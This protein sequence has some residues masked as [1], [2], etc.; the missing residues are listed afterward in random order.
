MVDGVVGS[1]APSP[2]LSEQVTQ[3]IRGWI[4]SGELK[5]G[6]RLVERE[7]CDRLEISRATLREVFRLLESDGLVTTEANRGRVVTM[8]SP[9]EAK[10]LYEAREAI[11]CTI[12]RLFVERASDDAIAELSEKLEALRALYRSGD[13][14]L[15]M[16]KK[17]EFYEVLYAGADNALLWKQARTLTHRAAR[18]RVRTLSMGNR[19]QKSFDEIASVFDAIV[20]RNPKLAEARWR[21]HIRQAA[22]SMFASMRSDENDDSSSASHSRSAHTPRAPQVLP[23]LH[24]PLHH[25]SHQ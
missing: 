17:D 24:T 10:E 4:I 22:E 19:P 3:V 12:V 15:I 9:R 6:S 1:Y 18:L 14:N 7:F 23:E 13:I 5:P 11:E 2:S 25:R 21:A 8:L 20:S 16:A